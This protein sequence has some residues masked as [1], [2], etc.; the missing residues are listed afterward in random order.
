M[1]GYS[2]S[3][4]AILDYEK[5]KE[6]LNDK[7]EVFVIIDIVNQEIIRL[8]DDKQLTEKTIKE[9]NNHYKYG[10]L[11]YEIF[12]FNCVRKDLAFLD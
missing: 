12:K 10:K 3:K 6:H 5:L 7:N 8:F 1:N 4:N 2:F 11:H 9:L